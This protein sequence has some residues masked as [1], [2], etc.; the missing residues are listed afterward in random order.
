MKQLSVTERREVRASEQISGY[1]AREAERRRRDARVC[2]FDHS[3]ALARS[4]G[5]RFCSDQDILASVSMRSSSSSRPS[6]RAARAAGACI[7]GN[8]LRITNEA[9]RRFRI[10]RGADCFMPQGGGSPSS[11][12][13]AP[14]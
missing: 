14:N 3:V 10:R 12:V 2:R 4:L 8:L 1:G 13:Q 5:R 7:V 11:S 9:I 6:K